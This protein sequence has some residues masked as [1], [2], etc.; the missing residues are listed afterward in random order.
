MV[1]SV[2]TGECSECSVIW[3]L[4]VLCGGVISALIIWI[5]CHQVTT[6]HVSGQLADIIQVKS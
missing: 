3:T 4:T 2:K 6:V 1:A 5:V